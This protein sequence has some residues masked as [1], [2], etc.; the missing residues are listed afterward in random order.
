MTKAPMPTEKFKRGKNATKQLDYT[1]NAD[2]LWEVGWNPYNNPTGV[3]T[4]P[5]PLTSQIIYV[6]IIETN[7]QQLTLVEVKY[8]VHEYLR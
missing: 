1:V 2:R 6:I 7:D 3:V 4:G 8:P 5:N